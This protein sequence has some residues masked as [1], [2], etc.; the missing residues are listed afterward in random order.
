MIFNVLFNNLETN[1]STHISTIFEANSIR[2]DTRSI[3]VSSFPVAKLVATIKVMVPDDNN[4]LECLNILNARVQFEGNNT[5]FDWVQFDSENPLDANGPLIDIQEDS[6]YLAVHIE[7]EL[8]VGFKIAGFP[9]R[10]KRLKTV[11]I[12]YVY[13]TSELRENHCCY[14]FNTNWADNNND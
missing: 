13:S 8:I 5:L 2:K 4:D 3:H 1:N 12:S 10:G 7:G 14:F 6:D 11:V 9:V